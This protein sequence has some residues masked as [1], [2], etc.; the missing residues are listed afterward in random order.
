MFQLLT[1]RSCPPKVNTQRWAMHTAVFSNFWCLQVMDLILISLLPT[2]G[3]H[4]SVNAQCKKRF[5][6][7]IARVFDFYKCH[8]V[9]SQMLAGIIHC[10]RD[11]LFNVEDIALHSWETVINLILGSDTAGSQV[12][13]ACYNRCRPGSN[14]SINH[15]INVVVNCLGILQ[16]LMNKIWIVTIVFNFNCHLRCE[17]E[18]T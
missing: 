9:A 2:R 10:Q 18:V 5:V 11:L 6:F 4:L 12:L 3:I 8:Q 14:T 17:H 7:K 1:E 16:S 15:A 13:F